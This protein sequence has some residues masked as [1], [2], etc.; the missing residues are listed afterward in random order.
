MA[1]QRP[2]PK[3]QAKLAKQ[4]Q[5]ENIDDFYARNPHITPPQESPVARGFRRRRTEDRR[6]NQQDGQVSPSLAN[7]PPIPSW[8]QNQGMINE[9][10]PGEEE[11]QGKSSANEADQPTQ[12]ETDQEEKETGRKLNAFRRIAK[13]KESG[14]IGKLAF[15]DLGNAKK[16]MEHLQKVYR[17]ING[18]SAAT[19][20]G[21]ILTFL[22][23]NAQLIFGNYFEI[24]FIPKL[25]KVEIV[26]VCLVDLILLVAFLVQ[27]VILAI[28]AMA[29]YYITHPME[30][31]KLIFEENGVLSLLFNI[32]KS[33]F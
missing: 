6:K 23:M 9:P 17:V 3:L 11:G 16:T 24:K 21:L 14:E 19:L 26:L 10:R 2:N 28:Y 7:Q 27:L 32:V 1:D 8:G 20:W 4:K 5:Q 18:A 30:N 31:W 22:I 12:V 33:Y 15:K 29:I 13:A 25:G